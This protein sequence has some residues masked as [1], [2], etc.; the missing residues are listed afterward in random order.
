MKTGFLAEAR[1]PFAT[2]YGDTRLSAKLAQ[3]G[4]ADLGRAESALI[5]RALAA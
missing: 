4:T 5:E 1:S 2:L 3:L